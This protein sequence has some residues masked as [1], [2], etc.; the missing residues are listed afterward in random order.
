MEFIKK[1]KNKIKIILIL[2]SLIFLLVPANATVV[3]VY[4]N[5]EHLKIP[6]TQWYHGGNAIIVEENGNKVL[7][8]SGGSLGRVLGVDVQYASYIKLKLNLKVVNTTDGYLKA[9]VFGY[10]MSSEEYKEDREVCGI[11]INK[12]AILSFNGT[13]KELTTIEKGWSSLILNLDLN[14]GIASLEYGGKKYIFEIPQT[15]GK[16]FIFRLDPG[17]EALLDEIELKAGEDYNELF[18]Q[19]TFSKTTPTPTSTTQPFKTPTPL[20]SPTPL[21]T[22]NFDKL[23]I[24]LDKNYEVLY[25][26]KYND[27]DF[28]IV[29]YYNYLP[30]GTGIE[31]VTEKG[32]KIGIEE[33]ELVKNILNTVNA[34]DVEKE[35][36]YRAWEDRQ[37][38]IVTVYVSVIAFLLFLIGLLAV[39]IW[40]T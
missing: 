1:S 11:Y 13:T 38:G 8:V 39:V 23:K 14:A 40:K 30:P 16:Y 21:P 36:L 3:S 22:P 32:F 19:Y 7:K 2:I 5:F 37:N 6:F 4:A 27:H 18:D 31:V 26:T 12:S 17:T 20:P 9:V 33:K 15:K 28:Y 10:P 25:K 29:K 24:I 35:L 34:S